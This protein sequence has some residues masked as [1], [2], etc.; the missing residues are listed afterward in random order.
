[1]EYSFLI[2][3]IVIAGL[4][5]FTWR[6]YRSKLAGLAP[7]AEG[8]ALPGGRVTAERLRRLKNPPWRVVYEIDSKLGQI[9]HVVIGP[10]GVVAIETIMI[11]R[12]H[13]DP[14][15]GAQVDAA[16]A[17]RMADAA[18]LRG[19]L[20]DLTRVVGVPCDLYAKVYWGNAQPD[21]PAAVATAHG[22]VAVDGHRLEEWLIGRPPGTLTSAQVDQVWQTVTTGIGRPDPLA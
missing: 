4:M 7:D 3:I 22:M 14:D 18:I 5:V 21:R 6:W 13:L 1:V 10:N 8:R 19:P 20:D 15:A 9:D 2:P 16:A 11:D 12:P 17:Q